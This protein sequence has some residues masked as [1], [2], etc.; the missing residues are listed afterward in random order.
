MF[1]NSDTHALILINENTGDKVS[2]FLCAA[3]NAI[4][5]KFWDKSE[6]TLN[7]GEF[8]KSDKLNPAIAKKFKGIQKIFVKV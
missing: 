3:F 5:Y 7:V 2:S 8:I 6:I 1:Q 4:T